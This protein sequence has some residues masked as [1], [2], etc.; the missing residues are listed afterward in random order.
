MLQVSE[1][2]QGVAGGDAGVPACGLSVPDEFQSTLS[3][4][5]VATLLVVVSM[6]DSP[7]EVASSDEAC[8]RFID[9]AVQ[10]PLVLFCGFH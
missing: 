1:G 8:E 2:K 5:N 7:A 6:V 10:I 9:K 4:H 3:V